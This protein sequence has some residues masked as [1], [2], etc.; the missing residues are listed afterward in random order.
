[1]LHKFKL[2][3]PMLGLVIGVA[4]SAFNTLGTTSSRAETIYE[5]TGDQTPAERS[6]AENYIKVTSISCPGGNNECAVTL[7]QDFGTHPDFTNVTTDATTGMPDG[8][9]DFVSN[10]TKL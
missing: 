4:L 9:S 8:G 1:M 6:Q 7:D 5:Y 10:S 2:G 3:L